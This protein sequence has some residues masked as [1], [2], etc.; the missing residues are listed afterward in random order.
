MNN[1]YLRWSIKNSDAT[2]VTETYILRDPPLRQ[3][4]TIGGIAM[5]NVEVWLLILINTGLRHERLL[6]ELRKG[7]RDDSI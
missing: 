5:L 6:K 1:L 2:Y 3:F 4:K 7:K